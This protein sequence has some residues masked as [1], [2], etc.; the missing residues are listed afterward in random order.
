MSITTTKLNRRLCN[1]NMERLGMSEQCRIIDHFNAQPN[2]GYTRK[3][4]KEIVLRGILVWKRSQEI[5]KVKPVLRQK[6]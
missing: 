1:V 4:I 2:S 6:C 5:N 3:E